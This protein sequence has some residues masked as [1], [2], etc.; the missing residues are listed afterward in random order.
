MSL[1]VIA[2]LIPAK[3]KAQTNQCSEHM[4]ISRTYFALGNNGRAVINLMMAPEA[5][6]CIAKY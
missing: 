5:R 3:S 1:S 2:L 4:T 6:A